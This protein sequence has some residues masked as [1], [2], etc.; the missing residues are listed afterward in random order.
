M[1]GG[2]PRV[3]LGISFEIPREN[4]P[5]PQLICT[6]ATLIISTGSIV[7][8]SYVLV[9]HLNIKKYIFALYIVKNTSQK[10]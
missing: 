2:A 4:P 10:H 8:W 5:P 3:S 7:F 1:G 6:S 9:D